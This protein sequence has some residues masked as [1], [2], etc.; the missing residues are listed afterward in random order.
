MNA[1]E[2]CNEALRLIAEGPPVHGLVP[3]CDCPDCEEFKDA[4][5]AKLAVKLQEGVA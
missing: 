3:D 5:V 1:T 4:V 2:I